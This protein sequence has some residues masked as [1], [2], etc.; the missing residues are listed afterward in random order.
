MRSKCL[1]ILFQFL[2]F[3]LSGYC[4]TES[5]E[6]KAGKGIPKINLETAKFQI[7]DIKTRGIIVRL[8]TNKDR[9]AAYRKA[10][11]A[12]VADKMELEAKETNRLLISSFV[13]HWTY[14]P[15]YFMES[16][17]TLK[18]LQQDSLIAKKDDLV[19]D[20]V[21]YMNR[22]SFYIIDFGEL[23]ANGP[24]TENTS[25]K[26]INKTEESNNPAS[27]DCLVL[28]D[29]KAQQLQTPF[30]FF[31]KVTFLNVDKRNNSNLSDKYLSDQYDYALYRL[32]ELMQ[33]ISP[34]K[35]QKDSIQNLLSV[36]YNYIVKNFSHGKFPNSVGKFNNKLIEYYCER[37]DKDR[38]ILCNDDP[39]Y[40]WQ[41]N[42]NIR[43]LKGLP[44]LQS[45]YK[46]ESEADPKFIK[47]Y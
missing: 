36:S 39:Y 17:N 5:S 28:K 31:T 44:K 27:E 16:Q 18:L 41:R 42:P 15:I 38:N 21:I 47:T 45:Q 7:R 22:D 6:S 14:C 4:Q 12:K 20:T 43:Y 30:P 9:I 25:I 10:G 29:S 1:F 32:P 3:S 24:A 26:E 2:L 37:L 23:M 13:T 33:L 8:K 40:W 11:A 46:A 34:T 19:T 35:E